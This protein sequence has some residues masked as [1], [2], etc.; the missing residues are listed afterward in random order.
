MNGATEFNMFQ[1]PLAALSTSTREIISVLLN[2]LKIIPT[3]EGLP[4]DWRGLAQLVGLTGQM[5]QLLSTKA[6]PT[7]QVLSQWKEGSLGHLTSILGQLDRW[8]VVDDT[9]E[10]MVEDARKFLKRKEETPNSAP[11][12]DV[13]IEKQI[14]TVADLSRLEQGLEPQRYDAFLLFAD[15]DQDFAD[16]IVQKLENYYGLKLCLKDRDLI[17]G[18]TFEHEAI[19]TVIAKRCNRLIVIA[20][21]N[22]LKSEANKFFVTFATALGID[23]RLR[24]VVPVMYK[25]CKMPPELQ[26]YFRLDYSRS[27]KLYDFWAKLHDSVLSISSVT[28][29]QSSTAIKLTEL[30]A[31]KANG[32]VSC[33]TKIVTQ[34][35]KK[36][37]DSFIWR[38]DS[39]DSRSL[40]TEMSTIET[41]LKLETKSVS[42]LKKHKSLSME[43]LKQKSPMKW[44][45]SKARNTFLK[46]KPQL[47]EAM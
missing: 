5:V 4:R 37:V 2:P 47:A 6:D 35:E 3:D 8:D 36:K 18:L 15:E 1:I 44:F 28:T 12:I 42:S 23:Q 32:E 25:A 39:V 31:I 43:S 33:E 19:M 7:W 41:S 46:K 22:F 11:E 9:A 21:P 40:N 38:N 13:D 27:G 17:G 34:E 45:T 26:Y 29:P 10:Y 16:L 30:P 14:L 24:K 20:S